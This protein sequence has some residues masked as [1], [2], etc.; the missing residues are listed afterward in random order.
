MSD[1]E[2]AGEP[3][4]VVSV[5]ELPQPEASRATASTTIRI[6]P[7]AVAALRVDTALPYMRSPL[8]RAPDG[9]WVSWRQTPW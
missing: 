2:A 6:T 3:D 8:P 4:A 1:P 5:S 7:S 9:V